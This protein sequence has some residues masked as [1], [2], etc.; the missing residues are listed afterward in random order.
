MI[1]HNDSR[2]GHQ[3][4]RRHDRGL[5]ARRGGPAEHRARPGLR[6]RR[7][8]GS[9][10]T[11]RRR[12]TPRST[13]RRPP[14]VNEGDAPEHRHRGRLRAVQGRACGC[15]GS[16]SVGDQ[17][18]PRHRAADPRGARRPRHL[19]PRRRRHRLRRRRQ[20][21]TCRP[22]TTPTRSSPT[23]TCR[24]TSGPSRNPAF[25]AQRTRG[26]HQRPARQGAARQAR[27]PAAATRSRRATCSRPGTAEDPPEIYPMGLRNPFRIELDRETDAPVRRRLL[28]GRR[29]GRPGRAGRPATASGWSSSEPA[30]YGWPYCATA[31]LPYVD[32]D[33]ATEH[34]RRAVRL[35]GPGQRLAAQHRADA[36]CP[37]VDA[38][39]DLVLLRRR[40]PSSPSS[41]PAASARWPA[42]RTTSTPSAARRADPPSPGRSYYDG[43]PLFYEWTRDYV[44]GRS[45]ST[46]R[47][48]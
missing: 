18:R 5:P 7:T 33:F 44:E 42:R 11:T 25:D 6:R 1:W 46:R 45:A 28:A 2:D 14:T 10:C 41:A 15:P 27:A 4:D 36:S 12:W 24:S 38:A 47:R 34:L 3:P 22:A 32:Y 23:A 21:A 30:N 9:T 40:P 39:G 43:M 17:H 8:A 35:R 26:Q 48:R 20:P 19:L 16:S 31:E 29:R 37:P 13:T